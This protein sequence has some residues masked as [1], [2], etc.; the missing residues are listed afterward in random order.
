MR[1]QLWSYN[2]APEPQ[3]IAPLSATLARGLQAL[4]HEVDVV[5]AHPHYPEPVWG[6]R[7]RPYRELHDGVRVLRLPL[8]AGRQSGLARIRQELS[9]TSAL[10]IA[11]PFL[12]RPDALIAVTPSFPALGVAMTASRL[13]RIPWVMWLQDIVTDGAAATGE[14]TETSAALRLSR[15]LEIAAYASA[16]HVVTVS[17]AFRDNLIAKG[18][19]ASRITRIFN[20]ASQAMADAPRPPTTVPPRILVLGNIGHTQGLDGIIEAFQ[21]DP[22]LARLGAE[23]HVI[24]AGV[25]AERARARIRTPRVRMPGVLTGDALLDAL[26]SAHVGV[27]SQRPDLPEFNLPSK[28]MTYMACGL[29]VL[30]SV[31]DG[32]EVAR[33]VRESGAGWVTD[34]GDPA[35]FAAAAASV[36]QDPEALARA[37]AAARRFADEQFSPE[38]V[39]ARFDAVLRDVVGRSNGR[40]PHDRDRAGRSTGVPSSDR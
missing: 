29:P 5:A 31:A 20:P 18:A 8:W 35:R 23:L 3:G 40:A 33:I 6:V 2:Y 30:A 19:D 9:F 27:V 11:A 24:G 13:R 22:E 39:A 36:L 26:R 12:G 21:D 32:S 37:A 34:A 1:L 4:G 10:A 14:L 15:R 16:A 38:R 7:L 28:L 17:D 25:V